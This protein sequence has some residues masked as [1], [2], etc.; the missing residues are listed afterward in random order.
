MPSNYRQLCFI[1]VNKNHMFDFLLV[2]ANRKKCSYKLKL[3]IILER[4]KLFSPAKSIKQTYSFSARWHDGHDK[5]G[6]IWK[7]DFVG[8]FENDVDRFSCVGG[9]VLA[10]IVADFLNFLQKGVW[11]RWHVLLSSLNGLVKKYLLRYYLIDS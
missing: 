9:I 7:I 5:I 11:A 2:F 4:S 3:K 10:G 1:N 8:K 6:Q